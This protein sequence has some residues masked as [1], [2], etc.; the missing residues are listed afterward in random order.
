M[1][2]ILINVLGNVPGV[3]DRSAFGHP[4]KYSYCIAEDEE[5][6]PWE[7]LHVE[8]GFKPEESAVT[9]VAALGPWQSNNRRGDSPESVL[10]NLADTMKGTN[11]NAG[12]IW[13]IIGPEHRIPIEA[14]QW[15]KRRCKETIQKHT[16]RRAADWADASKLEVPASGHEDDPVPVVNDPSKIV[17]VAAGGHAGTFSSV[18]PLW[19]DG[20][21]IASVTKKINVP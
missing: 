16:Y 11:P 20:N 1:R 2:L 7:P 18:I 9:C 4:G 8:R 3:L 13:A 6:S 19:S 17:L 14:Q 12:E 15:S 10:R 21:G 5:H